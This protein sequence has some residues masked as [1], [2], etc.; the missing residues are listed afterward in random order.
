MTLDTGNRAIVIG[1]SLGGLFAG[2]MLRAIGWQSISTN[3]LLM[4]ST[5]EAVVL[6]FSLMWWKR[7][8]EQG[9]ILKPSA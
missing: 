1:G 9:L 4:I 8:N 3:G 2:M 5:A 6:C 7:F